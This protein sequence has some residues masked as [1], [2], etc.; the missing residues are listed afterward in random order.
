MR[1]YSPPLKLLDGRYKVRYVSPTFNKNPSRSLSSFTMSL[2]IIFCLLFNL[3]SMPVNQANKI[4]K[5]ISLSS[6]MFFSSTLNQRL[7][8]LSLVPLQDSQVFN[9]IYFSTQSL[10]ASVVVAEENQRLSMFTIP[11]YSVA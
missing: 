5:S 4:S 3:F 10:M 8:F 1:W 2:A 11:S 7:S 9:F 6:A